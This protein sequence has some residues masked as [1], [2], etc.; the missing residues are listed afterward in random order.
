MAYAFDHPY[1]T[2]SK[3]VFK[4][5]IPIFLAIEMAVVDWSPVSMITLTPD[6]LHFLMAS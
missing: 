5:I 1:L 2:K 6:A 4:L 3:F